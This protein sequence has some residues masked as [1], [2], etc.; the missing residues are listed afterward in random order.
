MSYPRVIVASNEGALAAGTSTIGGVMPRTTTTG[1]ATPYRL[2]SAATTNATVVK[3]SAGQVYS[4][5]LQN[6]NAAIRYLKLYNKA[7]TPDETDVPVATISI[8]AT[9]LRDISWPTG[10][11][12]SAGIAFRLVTELADNGTTAVAAAE[13]IVNMGYA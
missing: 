10:L 13:Q 1:G 12:F 4:L 3:A 7:T 8:P 2:I 6:I 5:S 9:G 11:A